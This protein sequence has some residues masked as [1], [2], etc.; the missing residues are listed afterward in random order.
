[1][2]NN[3]NRVCF[4]C[5][6]VIRLPAD[7]THNPTCPTCGEQC[8]DLGDKVAVPRK[9]NDRAW[10]LLHLDCRRR[11]HEKLAKTS[12]Q[13]VKLLHELEREIQKQ[14]KLASNTGRRRFI[15]K[16]DA[17]LLVLRNSP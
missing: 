16:L 3:S 14:K 9:T 4:T 15:K 11:L 2:P 1:M 7:E 12:E 17:Q 5:R 8:F 6:V 13:N 10:R